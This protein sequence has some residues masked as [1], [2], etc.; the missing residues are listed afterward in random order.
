MPGAHSPTGQAAGIRR[1]DLARSRSSRRRLSEAF[2]FDGQR[3]ATASSAGVTARP[4]PRD[5][6]LVMVWRRIAPH[7]TAHRR[8]RYFD[9][10]RDSRPEKARYSRS[11]PQVTKWVFH[12]VMPSSTQRSLGLR[13]S[14][15]PVPGALFG[16]RSAVWAEW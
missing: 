6:L 10:L 11:C 8:M 4:V 16:P 5:A 3:A 7:L 13:P 9:L 12:R 14:T 1:V 2:D 15:S